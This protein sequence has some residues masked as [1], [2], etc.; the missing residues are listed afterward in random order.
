MPALSVGESIGDLA[1]AGVEAEAFTFGTPPAAVP[2]VKRKAPSLPSGKNPVEIVI[3]VGEESRTE[4]MDARHKLETYSLAVVI[5]GSGGH[6]LRDNPITRNWIQRIQQ[7][8]DDK[9]RATFTGLPVG[10]ELNRVNSTGGKLP[11]DPA[12]LPADLDYTAIPFEVQ[13]IETRVVI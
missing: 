7:R 9:A 2:V 3:V 8:V 12:G 5:V 10:S 11:F 1:K 13:T 4:P 6:K